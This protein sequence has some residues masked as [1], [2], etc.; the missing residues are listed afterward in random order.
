MNAAQIRKEL[1]FRTSRSSGSGGQHV[2]KVET[3]VELLFDMGAS[4]ALTDEEKALLATRLANR[5]N[6]N[7]MLIVDAQ[8]Y[9][10]QE[11]N[12]Q[13]AIAKFEKLVEEALRPPKPRKY[14]PVKANR[15]KRLEAKRQQ[16]QKKALRKKVVPKP[17]DDLFVF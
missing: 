16:S 1:T 8:L 10:S 2:N 12:K 4:L 6:K 9:R 11:R 14:K 17:K 5:I 13:A 7:G 3:R 15:K